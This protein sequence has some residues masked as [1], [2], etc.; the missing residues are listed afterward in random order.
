METTSISPE[1]TAGEI[2]SVLVVGGARQ[3]ATEY[4]GGK[5]KALRWVM[6]VGA[7]DVLFSMPARIE[8]LYRI[9]MKRR[10]SST[11]W[12][13]QDGK[14]INLDLYEKAE[15]VAWRQLLRWV[16]AQVAMI[17][18]GMVQPGEVFLAYMVETSSGRTLFEHMMDTKFKLLPAAK[19]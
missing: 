6:R 2:T 16:Q 3:I 10:G 17:D 18:T 8:P 14:P 1:K 11:L 19:Q 12:R 7:N 15:R 13:S 5:I 9:F 4:D